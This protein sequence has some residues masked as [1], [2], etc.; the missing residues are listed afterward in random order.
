M[1]KQDISILSTQLN[2]DKQK[3]KEIL[4]KYDNDIDEALFQTLNESS[5]KILYM[6]QLKIK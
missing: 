5:K 6:F 3:A 2:C 4:K 1:S